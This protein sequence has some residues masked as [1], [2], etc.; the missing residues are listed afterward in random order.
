MCGTL[1]QRQAFKEVRGQNR[2]SWQEE[3]G[4]KKVVGS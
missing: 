3:V 1:Q 2:S 4:L